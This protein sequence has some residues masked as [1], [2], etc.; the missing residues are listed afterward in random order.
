MPDPTY[1]NAAR[2]D[3][4]G[5]PI[6]EEPINDDEGMLPPADQPHAVP[7]A[8]EQR[9][10]ETLAERA[11]QELPEDNQLW[12]ERP[13][14]LLQ[15]GDE[16]VDAFDDEKDVIAEIG[17]EEGEALSAEEAAMHITDEP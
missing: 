10:G 7:T 8:V 6:L 4:E 13:G 1:D 9:R 17:G 14:Q 15:P 12:E 3:R 2:L 16:D 5:V 11:G